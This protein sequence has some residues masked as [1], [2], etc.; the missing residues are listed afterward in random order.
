MAYLTT[1][2]Q[3]YKHL[4]ITMD[5]IPRSKNTCNQKFYIYLYCVRV[6]IILKTAIMLLGVF[7]CFIQMFSFPFL[8]QDKTSLFLFR[9][10][11]NPICLLHWSPELETVRKLKVQGAEC[12]VVLDVKAS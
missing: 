8:N 5:T 9:L 1:H 7:I 3:P 10:D 11:I 2:I 6:L 4:L 12:M